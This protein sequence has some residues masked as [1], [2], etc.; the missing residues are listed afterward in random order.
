[1]IDVV[2]LRLSASRQTRFPTDDRGMVPEIELNRPDD[3]GLVQ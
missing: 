1:M 2:E 3:V